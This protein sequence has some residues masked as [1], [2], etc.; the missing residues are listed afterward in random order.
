MDMLDRRQQFKNLSELLRKNREKQSHS[1]STLR[2]TKL[3]SSL[4]GKLFKRAYKSDSKIAWRSS[5][6]PS[7]IM[8]ALDIIPFPP[9]SVISMFANSHLTDDILKAAE[10]NNHSRDT[11]S[12]LRGVAG[13]VVRD[14]MP[15][16]DVLIATSLYCHGSAQIFSSLSRK[17]GKPFYYI[18]VPFNYSRPYAI[19]FVSKQIED[20]TKKIAKD[21]GR[22]FNMDALKRSIDY[23]NQARDYFLK[24]NELRK[25]KPTPMLGAEAL[26]YA[27][28]LS[29]TFGCEE[30][31]EICKSLYEELKERVDKGIGSVGEEKFRILWRHLRPYYTAVPLDYLEKTQKAAIVFEEV[32]FVH[33]PKMDPDKPFEGLAMK[34]LSNPPMDF[35]KKWL[36]Y[37]RA[38][39]E[40]YEID[41][42]VEFAQW[43]CRYLI[44]NTQ[45][46][47]DTLEDKDIP[48]LVID[49]D[50][51]DR[52]DYSDGQ[53]KTR[54]DA[55]I[56]ILNNKKG[57]K[58]DLCRS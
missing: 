36:K 11:C 15:T 39:V 38:L 43:G 41:G 45:I 21:C 55:F 47:K 58:S 1:S 26:D 30:M 17:Y 20:I 33:W 16:P 49:G 51:I 31:V 5:F 2:A 42:I 40:D 56:E 10:D 25:S 46:V 57:A 35:Q 32:N 6:V 48:I 24:V 29:H 14:Y 54:I 28:M 8:F 12:F 22:D 44:A 37:T 9:E 50:C 7:E 53:I 18:E 52:R 27:I 4:I 19:E 34:L 3:R 13:S 23:S